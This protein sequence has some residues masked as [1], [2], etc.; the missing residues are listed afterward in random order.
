VIAI[1]LVII[2][3][4]V[5]LISILVVIGRNLALFSSEMLNES[6]LLR[7]ILSRWMMYFFVGFVWVLAKVHFPSLETIVTYSFDNRV[8]RV[9]RAAY[10]KSRV[11]KLGKDV[12]IEVG[13]K[14]IGWKNISIGDHSAID[15]NVIL[16][17]GIVDKT[18]LMVYNKKET[19]KVKDGELII[20]RSCHISKNV[21]I[22]SFGGVMIG[23]FTG[24]ASGAKIYS[25]SHHYKNMKFEDEIIYKFSPFAPLSEQSLIIGSVIL[26]GNNA[27]GLNSVIL[28]GVTVGKNS[29]IGVCSYVVEDIPPNCLAVGCPAK[30]VKLL[31]EK[32]EKV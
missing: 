28:P 5:V 27:L 11:F 32:S 14:A 6:P 10:W 30:V 26:E 8:G 19:S 16:E 15:R 24:I 25:L 20:G 22:Q 7:F 23:D 18:K 13:A 29:W 31:H 9:M 1:L 12:T 21:I 3:L 2:L 4:V 17:T